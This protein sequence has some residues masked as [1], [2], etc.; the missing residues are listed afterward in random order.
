V[1]SQ[2]IETAFIRQPELAKA[3]GVSYSALRAYRAGKRVPS[4]DVARRIAQA[5]RKQGGKLK[6]LAAEIERLG[7]E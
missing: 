5:L 6:K 4:P 1:I 7:G 3:A 2:A